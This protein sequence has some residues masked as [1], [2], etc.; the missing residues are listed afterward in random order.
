MSSIYGILN[1]ASRA[2]MAHQQS[3]NVT[4]NNIANVNTPGYSRQR[5]ML[6]TSDPLH[7][8]I[9][10]IG[11]GVYAVGVERIYDRFIGVQINTENQ[12]LGRWAAQKQVMAGVEIIFDESRGF[13]LSQ[14]ISDYFSAW[15]ELSMDPDGI[16]ERQM[17]ISKGEALASS[18]NQ[19][20]AELESA[21]KSIDMDIHG[22]VEN[23]SQISAQIADLNAKIVNS[24]I[25]GHT[26]NEYRDQRDLAL[27]ELSELIDISTF[28]D[29]SGSVKV[30][31]NGGRTL[32]DGKT[33]HKLSTQVNPG[34]GLFDVMWHH[35]D[36]SAVDITGN[37]TGGKMQGW[38]EARDV[39]LQD[40]MTRLND[41]AIAIRDEVNREHRGG[42]GLDESTNIDFFTGTDASDI[43]VNLSVVNDHNLIAAASDIDSLP[44]DGGN[45]V[46]I[47]DLQNL[48]ILNGGTVTFDEYYNA[49]VSD[50][51][52]EVVQI[53]AYYQHQ[54]DML[55]QLENYRESISGV[56]LDEEM[57]NLVKFQ[58]A[59]DASA[60]LITTTDE[61][62]QTVLNMV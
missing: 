15:Q 16:T 60:K 41:L 8:P 9:G 37:I 49:L 54:F 19:K 61:L 44:G 50:V 58:S 20:Y 17:L 30:T 1:M 33:Y 52:S 48:A 43:Q 2:L 21:Q 26:A 13:G 28:E 14:A 57:V 24:E 47:A 31:L 39:T 32:V 34:T 11:N 42:F 46:D 22:A 3:I 40:Y 59:Y 12:S 55:T 29:Q 23:I 27:K 4:G 53:D 6:S 18:F 5:L 7:S 10:T 35:H 36:G 25:S 51:G 38:L 45:A 62:I 56:S